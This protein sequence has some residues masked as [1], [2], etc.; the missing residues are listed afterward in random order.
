MHLQVVA[1]SNWQNCQQ[2]LT[3]NNVTCKTHIYNYRGMNI[4]AN[5][6]EVAC[7]QLIINTYDRSSSTWP[8]TK[9]WR[10]IKFYIPPSNTNMKINSEASQ[11][12]CSQHFI[13]KIIQRFFL[14][15]IGNQ[16]IQQLKYIGTTKKGLTSEI[17]SSVCLS[18]SFGVKFLKHKEKNLLLFVNGKRK[19]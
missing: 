13:Q 1:C 19:I 3:C 10:S 6:F 18:M 12:Y 15:I 8:S 5:I 4:V 11:T 7:C 2:H 14:S 17:D 16:R 9:I